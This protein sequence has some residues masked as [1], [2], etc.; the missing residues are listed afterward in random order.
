MGYIENLG[1]EKGTKGNNGV[2]CIFLFVGSVGGIGV[3]CQ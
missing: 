3:N 1:E 2:E